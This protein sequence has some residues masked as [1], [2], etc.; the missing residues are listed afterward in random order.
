[1]MKYYFDIDFLALKIQKVPEDNQ[2]DIIFSVNETG[3]S[4]K[5]GSAIISLPSEIFIGQGTV[6]LSLTE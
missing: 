4:T 1:M 6:Q 5:D 2:K 3:Y